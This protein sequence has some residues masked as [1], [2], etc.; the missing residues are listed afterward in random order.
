MHEEDTLR[1]ASNKSVDV[2]KISAI[3]M[4]TIRVRL[5]SGFDLC[6]THQPGFSIH[7]ECGFDEHT[8]WRERNIF[9]KSSH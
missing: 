1:K 4:E 3:S 6:Q 2:I 8:K 7:P 5:V 9:S